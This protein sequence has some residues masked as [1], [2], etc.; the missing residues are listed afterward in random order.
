M[1]YHTNVSK[2]SEEGFFGSTYMKTGKE[3]TTAAAL[4]LPA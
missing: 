2:V 4:P 3:L 1:R